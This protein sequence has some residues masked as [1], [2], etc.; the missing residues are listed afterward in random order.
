MRVQ[1]QPR[2]YNVTGSGKPLRRPSGAHSP[3][4]GEADL[5][6]AILLRPCLCPPPLAQTLRLTGSSRALTLW[7]R[8]TGSSQAA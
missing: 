2:T 4:T 8:V 1:C 3:P 6:K 7:V 5:E